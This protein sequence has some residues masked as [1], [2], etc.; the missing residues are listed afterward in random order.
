MLRG[1]GRIMR[2]SCSWVSLTDLTIAA[3][4]S[5]VWLQDSYRKQR[6]VKDIVIN[7][8]VCYLD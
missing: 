8:L 3:D 1:I 2:H 7:K 6:S 4:Q 5:F